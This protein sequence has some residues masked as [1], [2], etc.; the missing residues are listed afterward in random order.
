MKKLLDPILTLVLLFLA[1][2]L[3]LKKLLE[4]L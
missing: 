4:L 2:Q 3:L 1:I